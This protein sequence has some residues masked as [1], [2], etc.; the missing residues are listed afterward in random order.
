MVLTLKS[1]KL[2]TIFKKFRNSVSSIV[3]LLVILLIIYIIYILNKKNKFTSLRESFF[4]SSPIKGYYK[5]SW[6]GTDPP[7]DINW[8]F[9]VWFGGETPV[10]AIDIN[11]NNASKIKYGKKILNL[12]GGTNTGT[13]N[14]Q[15]DFDYIN[16]R[17]ADVKKAGWDGLCFDVEVCSPNIDFIKLFTDCFAKCKV[18]G[19]M[20]IVTMS[21]L[22]PWSCQQGTG[23]GMN[24]VN[25]WINDKNIDYI[26]PQL[27][28]Q[29]ATL[30][31][32]DL[33]VFKSVQ[34]KI[35]P[36]IPYNTDWANLNTSNIGITPAGYIIWNVQPPPPP[37]PKRN[38][39]GADWSTANTKCGAQ[40]PGGQDGECPS[41][42]HCYANLDNCPI[43][44]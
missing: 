3:L 20:V 38:Y 36:S 22:V 14:G 18:A 15:A 19:L 7:A 29:G 26:S 25:A 13:W 37:S 33:S 4:S 11:I 9:G 27:Y 42:Q 1:L 30:E 43:N 12:G 35:L 28:T 2:Q 39:C 21:H 41:G 17:L 44:K 24:L 23:Q 6:V 34:N 40:C 31:T 5:L 16:S 32:T 10:K 8:D